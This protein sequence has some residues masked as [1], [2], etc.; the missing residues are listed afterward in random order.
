M[1]RNFYVVTGYYDDN[2]QVWA[3]GASAKDEQQAVIR[4][5]K[6]LEKSDQG[7]SGSRHFRQNC[8]IVGVFTNKGGHIREV[9]G[10]ETVC[11]AIDFPGLG[12]DEG[13]E[14]QDR[15]GYT[16]DQDRHNYTA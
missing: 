15:E 10:H 12:L 6:D 7:E 9:L 2:G 5:V 13:T 4:A 16:D 1:K 14:G 3:Q 11:A 8:C